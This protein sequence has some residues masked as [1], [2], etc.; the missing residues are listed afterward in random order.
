MTV[1]SGVIHDIVLTPLNVIADERGA[2]LHML[3]CDR[4]PFGQFGE[5][6]FSEATAGVV[7][8]WKRHKRMTQN[9]AVPV[10]TMKVVLFDDRPDSP[11]FGTIQEVLLGR[12]DAYRLLTVPPMIWYGFK[13][14]G[15]DSALMA[16]CASIPH[17]PLEGE[18]VPLSTQGIPYVW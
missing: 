2:V 10:G 5:V 18:T 8:G 7:K 15:D 4:A 13:A 3:R 1:D 9:F 14:L 12:P 16:N 17:E 11:S 6:Y